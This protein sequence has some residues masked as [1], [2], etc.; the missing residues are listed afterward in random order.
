MKNTNLKNVFI[1]V[2]FW[3][4]SF[5]NFLKK[6]LNNGS[7]ELQV[8]YAVSEWERLQG[9]LLQL[10]FIAHIDCRYICSA[11]NSSQ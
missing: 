8:V 10:Q 7:P 5:L 2:R 1:E 6:Y 3:L 11:Y 9:R 4:K